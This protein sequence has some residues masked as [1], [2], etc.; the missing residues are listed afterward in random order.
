M[1]GTS[2]QTKEFKVSQ[3]VTTPGRDVYVSCRATDSKRPKTG[4]YSRRT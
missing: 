1:R 3:A 2:T 4:S